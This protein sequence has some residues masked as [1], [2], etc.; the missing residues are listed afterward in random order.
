MLE[1]WKVPGTKDLTSA[2]GGLIV[3][4]NYSFFLATMARIGL[5]AMR[6]MES[7][8]HHHCISA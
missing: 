5:E 4:R 2:P 6:V 3:E 1:D 7:A 8:I